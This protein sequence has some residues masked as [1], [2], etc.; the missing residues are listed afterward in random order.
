MCQFDSSNQ[1]HI[2]KSPKI[3]YLYS[4]SSV[5]LLETY[6]SWRKEGLCRQFLVV[7]CHNCRYP[8]LGYRSVV[9]SVGVVFLEL[10]T[11][12]S[13]NVCTLLHPLMPHPVWRHTDH[14]YLSTSKTQVDILFTTSSRAV[15]R[16]RR[17]GTEVGEIESF[18]Q[19]EGWSQKI[20]MDLSC[21]CKPGENE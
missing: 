12:V 14:S 11:T 4:K 3:E 17:K 2:Y 5:Y 19:C 6:H 8:P 9:L 20:Y 16:I 18:S 15:A 13:C 10:S 7:W 1:M 21:H